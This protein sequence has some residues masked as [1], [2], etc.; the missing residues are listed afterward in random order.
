MLLV[1]LYECLE[2]ERMLMDVVSNEQKG[3]EAEDEFYVSPKRAIM[4]E[5]QPLWQER[6]MLRSH[7]RS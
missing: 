6:S 7:D 3:T 1:K 4:L 5:G 2:R